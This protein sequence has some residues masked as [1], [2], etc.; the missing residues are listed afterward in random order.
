MSMEDM[1]NVGIVDEYDQN[2]RVIRPE[3]LAFECSPM[4]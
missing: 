1:F 2:D 4:V 3:D